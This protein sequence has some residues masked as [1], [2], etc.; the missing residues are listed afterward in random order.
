M[1]DALLP[2]IASIRSNKDNQI[3]YLN[4]NI[5][6]Y[7]IKIE[8]PSTHRWCEPKSNAD[9]CPYYVEEDADLVELRRPEII[10]LKPPKLDPPDSSVNHWTRW[11]CCSNKAHSTFCAPAVFLGVLAQQAAAALRAALFGQEKNL[12]PGG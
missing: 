4:I 9:N 10:N 1:Y 3:D 11:E 7:L 8:C 2:S 6:M 12:R 5:G